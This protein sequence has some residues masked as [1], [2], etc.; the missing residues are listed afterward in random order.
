MVT[1]G[2][3]AMQVQVEAGAKAMIMSLR[4]QA[5]LS[6]I[7]KAWP[8]PMPAGVTKGQDRSATSRA[9]AISLRSKCTM[10]GVQYCRSAQQSASEP[11]S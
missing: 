1:Q 8:T 3:Q 9:A 2:M 4:R 6:M 10:Q 5:C 7:I 11:C